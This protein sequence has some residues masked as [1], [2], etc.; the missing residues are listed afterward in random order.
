M[1]FSTKF[2]GLNLANPIVIGSSG[3]TNSAKKIQKLADNGA[4]AVVLKSLFEEQI[5]T[6]TSNYLNDNDYKHPQV[7]EYITNY[8]KDQSISKYLDLI[9]SAKKAVNIPIIASINCITDTEWISFAKKIEDAGADALE[10]NVSFLPANAEINCSD[11]EKLYFNVIKKVK[12]Q[13]DLPISLKMSSYSSGL[14]NLIK[15][16][17]WTGHVDSFVLFNRFY[18]PDIDIDTFEFHSSNIFSNPQDISMS[19]RWI[20]LMSGIVNTD[21]ASSTGVQLNNYLLELKQCKWYQQF[22]KKVRKLLYRYLE[23][24]KSG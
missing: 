21:L 15:T 1:D 16:L 23:N 13:I 7:F 5:L 3:L 6:E 9:R 22:I 19:L 20:A 18:N 8:A 4:G 14:A 11:Y 2:M 17:S 24:W 10:I 12:S